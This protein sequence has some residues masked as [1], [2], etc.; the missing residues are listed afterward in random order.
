LSAFGVEVGPAGILSYAQTAR[1][2]RL[3]LALRIRRPRPRPPKAQPGALTLTAEER[4]TLAQGAVYVG[5]PHHT[6]IPKFGLNAAP[7]EGA[8]TFEIAETENAKNPDCVV[9]PRKWARR[10]GEATELLQKALK[11]GT[12]VSEGPG[13]MPSPVWARDPED[14][15]IVYEARL[16]S[17]PKGYKAY[18]LTSFQVAYN[19][20]FEMP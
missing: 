19:I 6:D 17:P 20:P 5:S 1:L 13:F 15:E 12:F 9:C 11:D 10:A 7:R 8:V 18:P 2:E 4:E 14:P 16:C 3:E